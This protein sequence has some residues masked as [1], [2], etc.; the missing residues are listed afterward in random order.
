MLFSNHSFGPASSKCEGLDA[1]VLKD[2][3][4]DSSAVE[5]IRDAAASSVG[6]THDAFS[7]PSELARSLEAQRS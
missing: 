4:Q 1:D 7:V 2:N 6:E 5:E 3:V